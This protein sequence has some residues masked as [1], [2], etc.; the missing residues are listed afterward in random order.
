MA[1]EEFWGSAA[2]V[3][4]V[5]R[6]AFLGWFMLVL[7]YFLLL[8]FDWAPSDAIGIPYLLVV[9]GLFILNNAIVFVS[10]IASAVKEQR[11][12]LIIVFFTIGG[13]WI[14]YFWRALS[15]GYLTWDNI[16]F[17]RE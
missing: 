5:A 14:Y 8:T 13:T 4:L 17:G 9:F 6:L 16:I 10:A 12:W 1:E 15:N 2:E 3:R 11:I 7:A